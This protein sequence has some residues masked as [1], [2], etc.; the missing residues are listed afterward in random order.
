MDKMRYKNID[1]VQNK[2]SLGEL[3][4]WR[5]E[6][7]K[8]KKD[9]SYNVPQCEQKQTTYLQQNKEDTTVTWIGH[10]TFLVQLN[11]CT[12]LTDPVWATRMGF[13]KRLTDPGLA[14]SDLPEI[15]VI[16]ISHG[17]YDHLDFPTL[18]NFSREIK[19][20]VPVGLKKLF[21]QKGFSNV[22]EFSWWEERTYKD[23]VFSFVPAQHWTRRSPFD[24][25]T[26]HWGGW[27]FQSKETVYFGGDSG[28][29]REF[30]EIGERFDIDIALLPI[31]AYEPEWFMKDSHMSPEE[32][33]QTYLDIKAKHFIPMHYGAFRLADD[34]TAEA[35]E[36]LQEAWEKQALPKEQLTCLS[37]GETF[38]R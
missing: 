38:K 24:M 37:L 34:T 2:K 13:D 28:Y 20:F 15:D 27:M 21:T 7:S 12:I 14:I 5:K 11:G 23:I 29:F 30:K 18:K 10:S 33:V 1:D 25:N 31:G 17:H 16:V 32:A 19:Y 4:R 3:Y 26:S 9:M 8:K 22:E 36:R 35:L 6:R